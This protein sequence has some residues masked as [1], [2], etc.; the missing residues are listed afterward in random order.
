VIKR[1][2]RIAVV[3]CIKHTF[4]LPIGLP[5]DMI[6]VNVSHKSLNVQVGDG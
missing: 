3:F 5:I 2:Q 4:Q 6:N 1:I